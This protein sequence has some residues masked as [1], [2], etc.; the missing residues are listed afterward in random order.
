VESQRIAPFP[1]QYRTSRHRL[2]DLV[3]RLLD[4]SFTLFALIAGSIARLF[5]LAVAPA[6]V[7][8][9]GTTVREF[10]VFVAF[11]GDDAQWRADCAMMVSNSR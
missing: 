2:R 8:G 6:A 7:A 11:A 1:A 4:S 5:F 10:G 9:L 3:I